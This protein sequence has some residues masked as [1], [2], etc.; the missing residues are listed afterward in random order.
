MKFWFENLSSFAFGAVLVALFSSISH[1]QDPFDPFD[2]SGNSVSPRP[3]NDG[4]FIVDGIISVDAGS[5]SPVALGE[6]VTLDACASVF[7]TIGFSEV[8]VC[9][10]PNIDSMFFEWTISLDDG[11]GGVTLYDPGLVA[12]ANDVSGG[13][14]LTLPTGGAGD[15]ISALGTYI[16]RLDVWPTLATEVV[17]DY[18][19]S[20]V[21]RGPASFSSF[22]VVA[23]SSVPE[24]ESLL[25]LLPA[26]FYIGRRQRRLVKVV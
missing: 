25:I 20:T 6:A 4:R 13:Q 22:E 3:T 7:Q 23:A 15:I 12:G 1:A 11:A 24:P 14:F 19:L 8:S 5:Y 16:V 2:A 17:S 21:G 18:L 26:L 10:S 9:D